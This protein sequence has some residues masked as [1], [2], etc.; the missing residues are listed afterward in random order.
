MYDVS[1]NLTVGGSMGALA[2]NALSQTTSITPTGGSATTYTYPA[3]GQTERTTAGATTAVHGLGLATETTGGVTSSYIRDASGS[4][5][6]ER[7]PAGDF[8]YVFDGLG[9]VIALVDPSG[10]Q[11]A[12]YTYD[13]YG[14]H[15]TATAMNGAL[16]V[17]PWRWSASYLD[18]TGLYKLGARYYDPGL[19]RFTQV[20]PVQGGSCNA[21]DYACGDSVNSSDL[22]GSCLPALCAGPDDPAGTNLI[23]PGKYPPQPG[24]LPGKV[25]PMPPGYRECQRQI[26]VVREGYTDYFDVYTRRWCGRVY[27]NSPSEK[28]NGIVVSPGLGPI[29]LLP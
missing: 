27:H 29:L 8:Y 9:S 4:L 16:P 13:P 24:R 21:Y 10:T 15:A 18:A 23:G 11:R 17:N 28:S 12:A 14:D 19:G 6:A 20:D 7:T 1:G 25:R 3:A 26:G 22:E 5:I 2:Y